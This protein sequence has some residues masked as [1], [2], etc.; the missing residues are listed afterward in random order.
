MPTWTRTVTPPSAL[1]SATVA[2]VVHG[3]LL[4]SGSYQRTYDAYVHI[5]F[6]DHYARDWFSTWETR[7]YTGF[8]TTSYPPGAHQLIGLLSGATGLL[9][10]FVVVQLVAVVLLVAGVYRFSRL[11]VGEEASRWATA[12]AVV[13]S[14]IAEAVHVFGQLPTTLALALLLHALPALHRWMSSG[15]R[16]SLLVGVA[17]MAATTAAHHVTTLFGSVFF[18]GP[19]VARVLVDAL[20]RP[21]PG[22]RGHLRIAGIAGIRLLL[23]RRLVRVTPTLTRVA[24]TGIVLVLTLVVV[25]LP[26][27]LWSASDPI[28]QVPIPHDSR[29]SFLANPNAG[30]VFWVIPWG[31]LLLL[32]PGALRRAAADRA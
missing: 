26:Y 29:A 16:L 13:S 11:W 3:V 15:H 10:A 25:V 23:I 4:A 27:W 14:S 31:V 21:A 32:L 5:F 30:L 1:A 9:G 8:T 28:S 6:G 12:L 7:W 2:T 20:R 22:E 24:L 18:L 17:T 19:I